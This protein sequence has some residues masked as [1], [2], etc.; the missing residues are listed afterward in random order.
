MAEKLKDGLHR[1]PH[2]GSSGV[3]L[4]A[5]EGKLRCAYCGALFETVLNGAVPD[6]V[7]P[8]KCMKEGR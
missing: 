2:C 7:L 6:L 4:D 5:K 8:F 1:C 3:A